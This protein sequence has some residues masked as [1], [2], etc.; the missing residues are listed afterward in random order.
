MIAADGEEDWKLENNGVIM[1]M[2]KIAGF[3]GKKSRFNHGFLRIY[4]IHHESCTM[5]G[6]GEDTKNIG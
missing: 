4:K 1:E 5:F 2:I 6:S 3:I